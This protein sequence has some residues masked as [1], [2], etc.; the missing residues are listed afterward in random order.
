MPFL[1]DKI[2]RYINIYIFICVF[3][4]KPWILFFIN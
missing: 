1:F 4:C 3:R 2:F